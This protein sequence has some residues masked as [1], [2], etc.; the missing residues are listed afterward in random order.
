[1]IEYIK[2][3]PTQNTPLI[4]VFGQFVKSIFQVFDDFTFLDSPEPGVDKVILTYYTTELNND[5]KRKL[6]CIVSSTF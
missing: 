1:M 2:T 3:A 4:Y 6:F 5:V